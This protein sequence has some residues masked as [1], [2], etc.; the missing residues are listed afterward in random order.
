MLRCTCRLLK[1]LNEL[2]AYLAVRTITQSRSPS[3]FLPGV[4]RRT[5]LEFGNG[6][7][8]T[9]E[10]VPLAGSYQRA[11]TR[12][13]KRIMSTV[14]VPPVGRYDIANVPSRLAAVVT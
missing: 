4:V 9:W 3:A 13:A 11:R 1:Q 10:Y 12:P 14:T 2:S 8:A 7:L 6:E 5:L